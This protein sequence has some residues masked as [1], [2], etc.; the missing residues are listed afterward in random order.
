[1]ANHISRVTG[2]LGVYRRPADSSFWLHF[3][4]IC[5]D[6]QRSMSEVAVEAI[7]EWVDRNDPDG[8]FRK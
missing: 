8:E 3:Q 4:L 6:R 1:M 7:K 2:N 5:L